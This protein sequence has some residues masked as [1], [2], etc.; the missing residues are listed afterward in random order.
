[1][2]LDPALLKS[3]SDR[4]YRAEPWYLRWLWTVW[5]VVVWAAA[6]PM[7]FLSGWILSAM[8]IYQ[9]RNPALVTGSPRGLQL[10]SRQAYLGILWLSCLYYWLSLPFLFVLVV[11]SGAAIVYFSV[12][13]HALQEIAWRVVA[14]AAFVAI[15][16]GI[17][18]GR[19]LFVRRKF[20]QPGPIL[21]LSAQPRFQE[22]LT[23]VAQ[24]VGTRAVDTVFL[25]PGTDFAVLERGTLSEQLRGTAQRCMIIGVGLLEGM[26]VRP[27]KAVL[28]HEYGH[29][30]NRD[31]AGGGFALMVRS[32]L[33][34]MGRSL[35]KGGAAAWYS[36]AW[37]FYQGFYRGFLRVSQ[38]ASRLQEILADRWAASTYGSESFE[39]GLHHVIEQSVRFDAQVTATLTEVVAKKLPLPNLYTR[40]SSRT[41]N[42]AEITKRINESI[43]RHPG[44]YD[45]HPCPA[46]R[47]RWVSALALAGDPRSPADE[48][49]VWTLFAG[50]EQIERAMTAQV[51]SQLESTRGL[52]IAAAAA[53]KPPAPP[54]APPAQGMAL[55]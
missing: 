33:R 27:F 10:I 7:L 14:G 47:F 6:M 37:L 36:P 16:T 48:E 35:A 31:T 26:K 17:A 41:L 11:G 23:E 42:E 28:A 43:A 3:I 55:P 2:G 52:R 39:Q 45:S 9:A 38:G 18:I 30:S 13:N 20:S 22:V 25:T 51:R 1:V 21:D 8:T 53:P 32:S 46:D 24:H 54:P 49:Q 44:P 34:T 12:A 50:R 15:V 40:K 19:S 29:F 4:L 5:I